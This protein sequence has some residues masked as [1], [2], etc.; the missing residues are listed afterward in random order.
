[1]NPLLPEDIQ[2]N[3]LLASASPRRREILAH[4]GFEFDVLTT[5]VDES[6]LAGEDY[7]AYVRRI[8]ASKAAE[9][10]DVHPAKKI[11]SADTIVLC[12]G[13]IMGKPAGYDKAFEML[14]A[15]SGKEHEVITALSL[16]VPSIASLE[17][18]EVTRVFFR[19]LSEWEIER[20][21]ETGEPF[22]KA[23][24]YAIQGY[25]AAFVEKIDGCYFNVVGLPVALLFKLFD[26]LM[27]IEKN[28]QRTE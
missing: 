16:S 21:I 23:G 3:L 19:A 9:A 11:I 2:S 17:D 1:M 15:L 26:R 28:E 24:A 22:D 14:K 13:E 6:A 7:F 10:R 4:L 20:Y 5:D 18:V 27:S 8:A 12:D 25:A